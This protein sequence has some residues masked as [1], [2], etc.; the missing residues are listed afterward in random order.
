[1]GEVLVLLAGCARLDVLFDPGAAPRP[2]ETVK[3]LPG[4]FVPA[5]VGCQP[6]VVG[7][8]DAPS[9]P[10]V[11]RNN[12]LLASIKPHPAV[13]GPSLRLPSGVKPGLV[14]LLRLY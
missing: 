3:G 1:M 10:F 9:D 8:H 2:A 12:Y 11:G 6:I 13:I 4:R 7:V 14:L 5:R